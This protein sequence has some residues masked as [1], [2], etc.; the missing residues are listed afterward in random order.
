MV[1]VNDSRSQEFTR[2]YLVTILHYMLGIFSETSKYI[3]GFII[4][5]TQKEN[6]F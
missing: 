6:T 1:I 5:E 2:K 3:L 4:S